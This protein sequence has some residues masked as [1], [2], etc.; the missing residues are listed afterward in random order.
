MID[1]RFGLKYSFPH[2]LVHIVDNSMYTGPLPVQQTYDPSLFATIV[3]TGMPMGV[4]NQVVTITRSDVFNTAFGGNSMTNADIEKYGQAIE[5]PMS[6]IQQDA[7]VKL[8]R[9]TPEDATYA[10]VTIYAEWRITDEYLELR[11]IQADPTDLTATGINL[12]EFKN[13]ERLAKQ[14]F[15]KLAKSPDANN[16][17]TREVLFTYVAAGRGSEYNKFAVYIN[18]AD[19]DKR[20]KYSNCIYEFGTIDTTHSVPLEVERFT[21]SLIN[22]ATKLALYGVVTAA[23]TVNIQMKKRLEGSSIMIPFVNEAAIRK[24]FK[25]WQSTFDIMLEKEVNSA[26]IDDRKRSVFESVRV[27]LDINRFDPIYGL[28]VVDDSEITIPYLHLDTDDPDIDRLDNSH[29]LVFSDLKGNGDG[30]YPAYTSEYDV[31]KKIFT[32]KINPSL[33]DLYDFN[34]TISNSSVGEIGQ[35]V[36][37]DNK[38]AVSTAVVP[39]TMY[40]TTPTTVPTVTIITAINQ[41]SGA[42]TTIGI[43]KIKNLEGNERFAKNYKFAQKD[44]KYV[45]KNGEASDLPEGGLYLQDGSGRINPEVLNSM[46]YTVEYPSSKIVKYFDYTGTSRPTVSNVRE[47]LKSTSMKRTLL[48]LRSILRGTDTESLQKSYTALT[49]QGFKATNPNLNYFGSI[50]AVGYTDPNNRLRKF[51]LFQIEKFEITN[52]GND[53]DIELWDY[54]QNYY[55]ALDYE[56]HY[57]GTG[58]HNLVALES[59]RRDLL[60]EPDSYWNDGNKDERES[61]NLWPVTDAFGRIGSLYIDDSIYYNEMDIADA[62]SSNGYKSSV[63]IPP[64]LNLHTTSII[65]Y[66]NKENIDTTTFTKTMTSSD[67]NLITVPMLNDTRDD[68]KDTRKTYTAVKLTSV[69]AP[70]NWPTGYYSDSNPTIVTTLTNT[71][72][73]PF[74]PGIYY[75]ETIESDIHAFEGVDPPDDW[76]TGGYYTDE[77]CKI[78]APTTF[79]AGTYYTLRAK[80]YESKHLTAEPDD[81]ETYDYISAVSGVE[82]E[83]DT[84]YQAG[85]YY[86]EKIEDIESD[87]KGDIIFFD[88]CETNNINNTDSCGPNC[89]RAA[90]NGVTVPT[91]TTT[92]DDVI[93][94]TYDVINLSGTD[95][96]TGQPLYDSSLDVITNVQITP[97]RDNYITRYTIQ[98]PSLSSWTIKDTETAVPNNYY[99]GEYGISTASTEGGLR[100]SGGYSGFFDDE[101]IN[102]IE[103]KLKYSQLLVQAFRGEIDPRILSPVRVPAKF[104]FDA[105]YNT[106]LG[107]KSLPYTDPT[108]EDIIHASTIFTSD[109]KIEFA[110]NVNMIHDSLAYNDIDVKQAM[111]DLMIHRVYQGIP[112]DKRPIGPGSGLQV[113]FDSGLA[114]IEVIKQL[115]ES[116]KKRFTNPNASWDIGGY[117]SASNGMTYTYVK[118]IVD[119]LFRHCQQYTINKPFANTY[120]IIGTDEYTEFFPNIDTTD[121]DLE[122]LMYKSGGNCW[123]LDINH[124]LRRRSQRTLYREATGTSDLIQENNMRTLSQLVYLLQNKIEDWL[125]EY[126]DDSVL[127]SM[128]ESVNNIF[129]GWVGT[130]VEAL[131]IRFE[132]DINTDGGDIVVCYVNVTFRGLILRVPIIVNVNRRAS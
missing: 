126:S 4:D 57:T 109:E 16:G 52:N 119:N 13:P 36:R 38:Q 90:D 50:I 11:L 9:V 114:D 24:L 42:T 93:G 116:F 67:G 127:A 28:C 98:S 39:G 95:A 103:F 3:V 81:W 102:S 97:A 65:Q 130:R 125:F 76:S 40:L 85:T 74:T 49:Q 12:A 31:V 91:F 10:V 53:L 87:R 84:P 69:D 47:W 101:N 5:Y 88:T 44:E 123:V 72:T 82:I 30:T 29:L 63:Y 132:R 110:A 66:I 71:E 56:S 22:D 94:E 117:V 6:L 105:G 51:Y 120:S 20:R 60:G 8:I 2:T 14:T 34:T 62:N 68:I 26:T 118:R 122:E 33:C 27:N 58:V 124:C 108:V 86:I 18:K 15:T 7:P 45:S 55:A 23:D 121:W 92:I 78:P 17:W 106:V 107:I 77:N 75:K 21:A 70:E 89:F 80:V 131:D 61:T 113:Y 99:V 64:T 104:L 111:Y 96:T 79:T 112:E 1:A 48:N 41:Y 59:H 25:I 128:T 43:N 32:D 129:A 83:Q 73:K 46:K 35:K 115:N 19:F 37:D 54:P 100:V